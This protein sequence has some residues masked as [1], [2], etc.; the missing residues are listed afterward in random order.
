M[1]TYTADILWSRGDQDFV[2][3]RYSR[4]TS[5]GSTAASSSRVVVPA[6][7]AVPMSDPAAVDPEEAFVASIASC[8]MLWF[9]AM[10]AKRRYCVEHYADSARR[11]DGSER[12]GQGVR[13]AGDVAPGR[14]FSGRPRSRSAI[15]CS[16]SIIARTR[17]ASSPIR[18]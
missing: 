14:A 2:A 3:N 13:S 1:A 9:L 7:R 16:H 15:S 11:D 6:R 8:H 17:S 5:S 4:G 12:R 10:A 18:C